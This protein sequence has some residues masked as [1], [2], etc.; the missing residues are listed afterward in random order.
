MFL[1]SCL[2][3]SAY[4]YYSYYKTRKDYKIIIYE[5]VELVHFE[6]DLYRVYIIKN[7]LIGFYFF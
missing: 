3:N 7:N 2:R 1:T 5:Y 6:R 4:T